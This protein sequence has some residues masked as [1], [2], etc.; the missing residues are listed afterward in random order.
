MLLRPLL[1]LRQA[2]VSKPMHLR[3]VVFPEPFTP[4]RM[5]TPDVNLIF[6]FM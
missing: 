6:R 5:L 1:V 4:I 2:K 3:I